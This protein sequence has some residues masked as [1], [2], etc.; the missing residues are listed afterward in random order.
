MTG[1]ALFENYFPG[2][3]TKLN[4]E[5]GGVPTG[6]PFNDGPLSPTDSFFGLDF[7]DSGGNVLAG[8]VEKELKEAG[9]LSN[10][11][12]QQHTLVGTAPAGTT[13]VRV[14]ATML[15]GVY[16]PLPEPQVYQMSFLV[17]DFMLTASAGS[18][19]GAGSVPEPAAGALLTTA[20]GLLA[21]SLRRSRYTVSGIW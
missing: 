11:V 6:A 18:G 20:L 19:G 3:V 10:T 2:G 15:D 12:W 14:R 17:D 7:L 21:A 4:A 5:M 9:Q 1:W 8:S 13:H 16:N